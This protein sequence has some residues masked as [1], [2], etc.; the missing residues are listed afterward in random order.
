M[1]IE[2]TSKVSKESYEL[3][4]GIVKFA[5]AIK[6]ALSDGWQ[7]G[8]DIPLILTAAM[9]DLVPS[10]QGVDAVGTE[11]EEHRSAFLKAWAL[12][13]VEIAD[14]FLP[15]KVVPVPAKP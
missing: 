14:V 3:G 4:Q 1:L 7:P 10:F 9:T 12:C 6:S 8:Q 13:G 2:V 11:F 5:S 15:A